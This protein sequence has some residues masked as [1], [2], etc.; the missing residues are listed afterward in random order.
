V[1]P[2][3]IEEMTG[4]VTTWFALTAADEPMILRRRDI[5]Q[6]YALDWKLR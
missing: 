1:A 6:V 3:D 2:V 5:Q 4:E